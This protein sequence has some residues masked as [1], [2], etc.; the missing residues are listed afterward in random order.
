MGYGW[1]QDFRRHLGAS[2]QRTRR[3]SILHDITRRSAHGEPWPSECGKPRCGRTGSRAC[4]KEDRLERLILFVCRIHG[5]LCGSYLCANIS[6]NARQH[7][8]HGQTSFL[9]LHPAAEFPSEEGGSRRTQRKMGRPGVWAVPALPPRRPRTATLAI[10][11]TVRP[12][13]AK[14]ACM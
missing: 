6:T 7:S 5:N 4:V 3:S 9:F 1:T 8:L 12:P 10:R 13:G 2:S 14:V 11:N